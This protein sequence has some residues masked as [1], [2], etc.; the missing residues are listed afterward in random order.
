M[1]VRSKHEAWLHR[2]RFHSGYTHNEVSEVRRGVHP[3]ALIPVPKRRYA[4]SR[5]HVGA[6]RGRP[7]FPGLPTI[8]LTPPGEVGAWLLTLFPPD[9]TATKGV[10]TDFAPSDGTGRVVSAPGGGTALFRE[11]ERFSCLSES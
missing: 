8:R 9:G 1:R 4:P 2:Q 11:T 10:D 5:C 6:A 3:V 7:L